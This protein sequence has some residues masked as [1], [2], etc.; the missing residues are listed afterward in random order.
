MKHSL[1]AINDAHCEWMCALFVALFAFWSTKTFL[2][3]MR[4]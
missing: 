3:A 4:M 2:M 1:G